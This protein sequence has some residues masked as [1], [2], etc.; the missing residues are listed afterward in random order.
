MI[1]YKRKRLA[2]RKKDF[3][4]LYQ[5]IKRSFGNINYVHFIFSTSRRMTN[6]CFHLLAW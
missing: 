1:N 2:I 3:S 5:F 4:L 6:Y